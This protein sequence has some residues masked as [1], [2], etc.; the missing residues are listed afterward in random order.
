MSSVRILSA[1]GL[2]LLAVG[3]AKEPNRL[4]IKGPAGTTAARYDV[5][6]L[7]VFEAKNASIKLRA[8]AYQ[9]DVFIG[10]AEVRWSSED[11][12]IASVNQ[13]GMVTILSSGET[14]IRAE[15][16]TGLSDGIDVKAVIIDG[17][18]ITEPK[19]EEG[20]VPKLPMGEELKFQ[21]VVKNDRGEVIEDA[22][23]AWESTTYAAIIGVDGTV[24]GGAIGKTTIRAVAKNGDSDSV[25]IEVTD[26]PKKKRRR[27]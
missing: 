21:A 2:A 4:E 18:E 16:P 26:W 7:P 19:L 25:E 22:K 12:S 1:A 23:I 27:R 5:K 14:V 11:P 3:C 6:E 10:T 20:E 15:L 17:V 13:S 9:D 8:I 24:E